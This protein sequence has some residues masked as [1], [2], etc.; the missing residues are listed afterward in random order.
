[1]DGGS[2]LGL[3]PAQEA[4]SLALPAEPALVHALALQASAAGTTPLTKAESL[5]DYF[6]SG[7]FAYTLT[8]PHLAA[9][10]NPLVAFLTQTR[11]GDCEQF[12]GAFTVLA[13]SLGLP[14]RLV[15]GFT[16][17]E[18]SGNLTVVR[19]A[20]PMPGPRCTWVSNSVGFPLS[21][22]RAT[23]PGSRAR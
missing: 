11:R 21:R 3:P 20:T 15:V 19:G 1:M 22:H 17:G 9:D 2:D 5:V 6:R 16:A 10:A 23:S 14:T 18:R 13:R 12:A 4:Q 7:R 8:P